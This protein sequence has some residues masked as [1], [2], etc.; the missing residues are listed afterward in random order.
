MKRP[1]I[2]QPVHVAVAQ[3]LIERPRPF[4]RR[5]FHPMKKHHLLGRSDLG[6]IDAKPDAIPLGQQYETQQLLMLACLQI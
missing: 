3:H 1:I 2:K 5:R 6:F 4:S